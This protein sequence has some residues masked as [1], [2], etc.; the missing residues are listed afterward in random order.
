MTTVLA[1]LERWYLA[2]C[3]G[4]RE[5]SFGVRITTLDNPGWKLT[6]DLSGSPLAG[7]AFERIQTDRTERDWFW[8]WVEEGVFNGAGGPGNLEEMLAAFVAWNRATGGG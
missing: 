4:D 5:H 3:N 8:C 6:I 2:Q 1:E 7:V